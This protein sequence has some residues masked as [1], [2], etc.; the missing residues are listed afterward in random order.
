MK[1][2][3]VDFDGTICHD[4]FWRSLNDTE[5]AKIQKIL[6][7]Q[8]NEMVSDWMKGK[9]T[10]EE[11]NKFV[12]IET[13][14]DYAQV[15]SVFQDDCKTMRIDSQIFELLESLRD[16]YHLVLVTG[17]MDCFDRF[18]AP[19]LHLEKYFDEIVNSFNEQQLKTEEGGE[20]FL[21][22]LK[23]PIQ[24]SYLIEDSV[25]SCR[26]FSKL[27]GTA[28]QVNPTTSAVF[29]LQHLINLEP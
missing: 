25:N 26:V 8:N 1:T 3:F 7:T 20:T 27:G 18:T 24:K 15:W 28:L 5:Y 29:H 17:N 21:K 22:Y 13:G 4:R 19:T 14:I 9:Y 6:F 16:Y 23:G 10:A 12:A 11:I 2:L